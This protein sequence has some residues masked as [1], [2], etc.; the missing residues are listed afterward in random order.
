MKHSE[1]GQFRKIKDLVFPVRNVKRV[2]ETS[3]SGDTMQ[4]NRTFHNSGIYFIFKH[5]NA[6]NFRL[7]SS[8]SKLGLFLL[9]LF[10]ST[11]FL[12]SLFVLFLFVTDLLF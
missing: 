4:D 5:P 11:L 12:A 1:Q 3:K 7:N 10:G 2:T 6:L 9:R 8:R